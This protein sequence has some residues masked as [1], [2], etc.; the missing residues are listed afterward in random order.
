MNP[1]P[2][3]K[4][5]DTIGQTIMLTKGTNPAV[6]VLVVGAERTH[7]IIRDVDGNEYPGVRFYVKPANGRRY[8]T[9]TFPDEAS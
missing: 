2:S 1:R 7:S 3:Q 8:W 5:L 4:A 9:C 6:P